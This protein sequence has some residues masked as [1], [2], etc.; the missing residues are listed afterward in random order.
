MGRGLFLAFVGGVVLLGVDSAASHAANLH[1]SAT[2]GVTGETGGVSVSDRAYVGSRFTLTDTVLVTHIGGHLVGAGDKQIFGA[3][4][5]LESPSALPSF[6][7]SALADNVLASTAFAPGWPS[8]DV[9]VPLPVTLPPGDY[10]LIFG[11]GTLGASGSGGMTVNNTDRVGASYFFARIGADIW[12]DSR[13]PNQR[14][15]VKGN[16]I[17]GTPSRQFSHSFSLP[18]PAWASAA[19]GE[20]R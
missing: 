5:S 13:A 7:P 3:I 2:L 18:S 20:E 10:A 11:S 16:V 19:S 12:L 17:S 9:L 1:E 8:I 4:V 15:V 14:F 6:A